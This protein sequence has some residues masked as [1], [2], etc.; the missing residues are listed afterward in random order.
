M[1]SS[2]CRHDLCCVVRYAAGRR[3]AKA[4][5]GG[6]NLATRVSVSPRFEGLLEGPT[7]SGCRA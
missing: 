2:Q 4:R 1:V 7:S 5:Y 6:V 3:D